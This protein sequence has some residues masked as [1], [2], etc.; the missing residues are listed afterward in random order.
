MERSV[1]SPL[2]S[3]GELAVLLM[4]VGMSDHVVASSVWF[5]TI[6]LPDRPHWACT[7]CVTL[8]P[9]GPMPSPLTGRSVDFCPVILFPKPIILIIAS[10]SR[11]DDYA[12]F[13]KRLL[14]L[15]KERKLWIVCV[16][17]CE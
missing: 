6:S 5:P 15:K 3:Q 2:C 9:L 10:M 17:V 8:C 1:Q 4:V 16:C 7:P 14:T 11:A 13:W 12:D